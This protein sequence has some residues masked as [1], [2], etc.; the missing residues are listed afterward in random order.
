MERPASEGGEGGG[1]A[2][3]PLLSSGIRGRAC[4]GGPHRTG[5]GH[6]GPSGGGAAMTRSTLGPAEIPILD[7][8]AMHEALAEELTRDFR[9]VLASGQFIMGGEHD[10]FETELAAACGT[11]HAVGMAS[12]TAALSVGLSALG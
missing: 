12:G 2:D 9:R 7:L 1:H 8:G 3:V 6:D 10:A 5:A 11:R 4:R